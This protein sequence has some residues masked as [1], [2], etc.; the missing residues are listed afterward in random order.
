M[1]TTGSLPGAKAVLFTT[2][3]AWLG[4]IGAGA[5]A[6]ATTM[7]GRAAERA[8]ADTYDEASTLQAA[9]DF[10]GQTT[11][12]LARVIARPSASRDSATATSVARRSRR[13]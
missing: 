3:R 7:F 6:L 1:S 2:R 5:L 10:F 4:R 12:E 13:P 8:E 11:G 9:V